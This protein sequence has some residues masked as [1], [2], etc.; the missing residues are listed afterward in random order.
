MYVEQKQEINKFIFLLG[1]IPNWEIYLTDKQLE[2]AKIF[3]TTLNVAKTDD[4]L[5]LTPGSSYKR[6]FGCKT[7]K[8]A[9]G[10]LQ[11]VYTKLETSG[12]YKST[13][14]TINDD[15][16]SDIKLLFKIITELDDYTVYLSDS[17]NELVYNFLKFRS[18]KECAKIYNTSIFEIKK[19]LSDNILNKLKTNYESNHVSNW[20]DI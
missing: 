9:I 4:I 3:I 2:C 15:L 16:L 6:L 11:N 1:K 14:S 8:G 13:I 10:S 12:Y 7:S 17:E 18:L 20:D 5:K 19:K